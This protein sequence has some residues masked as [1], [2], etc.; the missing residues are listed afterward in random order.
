MEASA[1]TAASDVATQQADSQPDA[2]TDAASEAWA[3]AASQAWGAW[4]S[5]ATPA[6]AAAAATS[7]NADAADA[8]DAAGAA[9]ATDAADADADADA[10]DAA[11]ASAE[12]V[13]HRTL[14]DGARPPRARA[15]TSSF[16]ELVARE[17]RACLKPFYTAGRITSREDFKHLARELTRKLHRDA[18]ERVWNERMEAKVRKYVDRAFAGA[19]VYERGKGGEAAG[20]SR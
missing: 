15:T 4:S 5:S 14:A 8:A 20:G 11:D 2:G 10:A 12:D 16:K 19:F 18:K 6:A 1:D 17:V 13:P 9:D 3:A 7:N